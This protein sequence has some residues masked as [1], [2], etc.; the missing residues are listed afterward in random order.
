MK[1]LI[2]VVLI[3]LSLCIS[4]KSKN[5]AA[6]DSE[7]KPDSV[8]LTHVNQPL[9]FLTN[10]GIKT[11]TIIKFDSF[12]QY[13]SDINIR[14][15]RKQKHK[16]VREILAHDIYPD[17]II[18][19]K[20][21]L[22]GLGVINENVAFCIY[23]IQYH[24]DRQGYIAT[25]NSTGKIIDAVFIGEREK[26]YEPKEKLIDSTRL[27][28]STKFATKFINPQQFTYSN[29]YKQIEH[30]INQD[31]ITF[32]RDISM[33]YSIGNDGKIKLDKSDVKEDGI[34]RGWK[35]EKYESDL[36]DEMIMLIRYPY[37]DETALE[38]WN[39]LGTRVDGAPAESFCYYF[40]KYVFVPQ[41][42]KVLR[43]IYDNRDLESPFLP[44]AIEDYYPYYKESKVFVDSEIAKLDNTAMRDYYKELKTRWVER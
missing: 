30:I 34:Y 6:T 29:Q 5:P 31:S 39:E 3:F 1:N 8:T 40:Y 7:N 36:Y 27:I 18:K 24:N 17:S 20:T 22:V 2:T 12:P 15:N 11:D 33:D 23:D 9:E 41:P 43:W 16:L 37:S 28:A 10:L 4:C 38:R 44:M 21:T 42:Q 26:V 25:Y 13:K 19:A 14:L 35:S 32:L